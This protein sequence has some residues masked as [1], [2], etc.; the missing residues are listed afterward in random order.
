[1][2]PG[3]GA[4]YTNM[5]ADLCLAFPQVREWF[6]FLDQTFWQERPY[7]PSQVIFPPPTS[8]TTAEELFADRQLFAMDI[9]SETVFTVPAWPYTNSLNNAKFPAMRWWVIVPE[10]IRLCLPPEPPKLKVGRS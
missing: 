10:K 9:G 7:R 8:L 1:M 6:D 3:E 2:F 4:Q 5:L